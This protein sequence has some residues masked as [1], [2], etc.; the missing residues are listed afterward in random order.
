MKTAF[1]NLISQRDALLAALVGMVEEAQPLGIDRESYLTA[2]ALVVRLEDAPK[3][4]AIEWHCA[5]TGK[6]DSDMTVLCWGSEG[7]FCG[8]WDDSLPGWIGCES[9]GSVLG[10]THWA[11]P[12]GPK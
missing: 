2:I 6:P 7:F 3:L 4:E 1:I 5:E 11:T 8:Y 10:V 12:E 9:G